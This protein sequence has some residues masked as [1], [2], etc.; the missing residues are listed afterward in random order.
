M[1]GHPST[2]EKLSSAPRW[3]AAAAATFLSLLFLA[4]V[5][6]VIFSVNTHNRAAFDQDTY[7]LPAIQTFARQWPNFDFTDY[8]AATTPGYHVAMAAVDRFITWDVRT[9]RLCGALFGVGLLA[10]LTVGVA[11]RA[12]AARGFLLSLPLA[13]SIY[14]FSAAAWTLPENAGWWGVAALLLVALRPRVDTWTFQLSALLLFLLVLVRQ[15][16]LWVAAPLCVAAFIGNELGHAEP[17]W[18]KWGRVLI[19]LL[20]TAPAVCAV[21]RF[22]FIWGG[23]TPSSQ[24]SLVGGMNAAGPAVA[25]GV[26]GSLGIFFLPLFVHRLKAPAFVRMAAVGAL[27]GLCIGIVP[28]STYDIGAGRFSGVWNAV[29]HLP[30]FWNRSPVIVGLSTLGGAVIAVWLAALP[31]RARWIWTSVIFAFGAAQVVT[32]GA[33]QRYDEPMV[34]IAAALSGADVS[35]RAPRWA[36]GGAVL[37]AGILGGITWISLR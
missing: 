2:P 21:A 24:S 16:D 7:H 20:M 18:R 26:T 33:F 1:T 35:D 22:M 34:L 8:S 30:T 32:H 11:C 12:G 10:T 14:V 3:H 29:P 13:C 19:M 5:I 25:L 27:F 9:L 37:L 17:G 6:S 4:G 36:W 23:M 15:S 28:V 31:A